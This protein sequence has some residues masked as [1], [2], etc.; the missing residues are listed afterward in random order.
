MSV[1]N[2]AYSVDDLNDFDTNLKVI[3]P[4]SGEAE[5]KSF[6]QAV[7]EGQVDYVFSNHKPLEV[8]SKDIEFHAA[9]FGA[10]SIELLFPMLC[11]ALGNRF[12]DEHIYSLLCK[13]PHEIMYE[14]VPQIKEGRPAN[15]TV[16]EQH[17][18]NN[19]G[20]KILY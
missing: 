12:R 17:T 14:A 20:Q 18:E 10:A 8:E 13:N 3:P 9:E 11:G 1:M 19:T 7:L 2:L 16:Y 4:I 5:R 15:V 6:I